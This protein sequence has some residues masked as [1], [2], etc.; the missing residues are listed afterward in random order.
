VV[1]LAL[2]MLPASYWHRLASITDDNKDEHA[3]RQAR[4]T[5]MRESYATFLERPLTGVGAGQFK[6]YKPEGRTE[7]WRESHNALLQVA[8]ELG[9]LGVAAF[10]FLIVRGIYAPMQTRRL[11]KRSAPGRKRRADAPPDPVTPADREFLTSHAA[12]MSAALAGW[13]V[14]SLF[15]SV[16]YHWTLYYLLALAIGPRE[17]L[18]DLLAASRPA[19]RSSVAPRVIAEARA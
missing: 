14:C 7:A 16:A 2:P 1:V 17:Y 6:N 15:A 5:L 12:A 9:I 8:A 18:I 13:F 11:L 3:S 4:S 10:A 19:R